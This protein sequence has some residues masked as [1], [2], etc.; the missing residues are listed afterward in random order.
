VSF[1]ELLASC[2]EWRSKFN[3]YWEDDVKLRF[4]LMFCL[5]SLF[6]VAQQSDRVHLK[7]PLA[8]SHNLPF[9]SG[10]MVGDTLYIA[11]TTGVDPTTKGP[12][13]PEE[14]AKLVMNNIKQVVEQAGLTMDDIVVMQVYCTDLSKYDAFNGVYR[15]YFKEDFPARAFLGT[16]SLLFGA[17]FE[18][19]GMA[20]K[21]KK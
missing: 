3:S 15:T 8:K 1:R 9:S 10:V 2:V 21:P 13:T 12:V 14:E 6:S 7:A 5:V 17:R 16:S 11:G 19:M 20:V 18:V 4:V